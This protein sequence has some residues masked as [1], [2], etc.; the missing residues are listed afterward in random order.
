MYT[1][2]F[3]FTAFSVPA[4]VWMNQ[5]ADFQARRKNDKVTEA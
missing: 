3:V 5:A 2:K 1:K 4:L